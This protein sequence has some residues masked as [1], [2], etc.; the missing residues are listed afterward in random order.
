MVLR[1]ALLNRKAFLILSEL[2][3]V[4]LYQRVLLYK[5][6]GPLPWASWG[7]KPPYATN[8]LIVKS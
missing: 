5:R 8:D 7:P 4:I 3:L 1:G 6:L 2:I